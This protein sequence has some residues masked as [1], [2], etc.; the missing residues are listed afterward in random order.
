MA[1]LLDAA[2]SDN[3]DLRQLLLDRYDK[4]SYGA[5]RFAD[6]APADPTVARPADLLT[7]RARGVSP[8]LENKHAIRDAFNELRLDQLPT[9]RLGLV[10][11]DFGLAAFDA[12]GKAVPGA[13][14][15]RMQRRVDK[16]A[17]NEKGA[18][19]QFYPHKV[20]LVAVQYAFANKLLDFKRMQL[21]LFQCVFGRYLL[22]LWAWLNGLTMTDL[23]DMRVPL[24][25]VVAEVDK[26]EFPNLPAWVAK[27]LPDG[28][29]FE[30]PAELLETHQ[31]ANEAFAAGKNRI[32]LDGG[33]AW[34]DGAS[35]ILERLAAAGGSTDAMEID[36]AAPPLSVDALLTFALVADAAAAGLTAPQGEASGTARKALRRYCTAA[37]DSPAPDSVLAR[38]DAA[39]AAR[40]ASGLAA[41]MRIAAEA[42]PR[43]DLD[44]FCAVA[45]YRPPPPE[46]RFPCKM[47]FHTPG[48]HG[49]TKTFRIDDFNAVYA[50]LT[51]HTTWGSVPAWVF[52]SLTCRAFEASGQQILAGWKLA[53]MT[54]PKS[55]CGVFDKEECEGFKYGTYTIFIGSDYQLGARGQPAVDKCAC[56]VEA[57]KAHM[58]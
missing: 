56:I 23:Q 57:M 15:E 16:L 36:D 53:E 12:T 43:V 52:D 37:L 39:L 40:G 1:V 9:G 33:A 46:M 29:A 10:L 6:G 41:A 14:I 51:T 30:S 24:K 5:A 19:S 47:R 11:L 35:G 58:A 31:A 8:D 4:D 55:I 17:S 54:K 38:V 26:R 25:M 42:A 20:V 50:V 2:R 48:V 3:L 34:R 32:F 21:S 28:V 18:G 13:A 45:I 49:W 7:R 44:L 22:A 27:E